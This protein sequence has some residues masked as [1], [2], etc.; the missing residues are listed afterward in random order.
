MPEN[1]GD[2]PPFPDGDSNAET[3]SFDAFT[4]AEPVIEGETPQ[5]PA[6][7][8]GYF[9]YPPNF[10]PTPPPA[11]S[12]R[13]RARSIAIFAGVVLLVCG[14]SAGA[15]AAFGTSSTPSQPGASAT[16]PATVPTTAR[17][18][19][20][21]T[22][23]ITVAAFTGT[24]LTG[25]NAAGTAVTVNITSTTRYGTKAHP[26]NVSQ[27]VAGTVVIVRGQRDGA[28]TI[29]ATIIVG[30]PAAKSSVSATAT[31]TSP[32]A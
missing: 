30:A 18:A 14:V 19:K 2:F 16:V 20:L 12:K 3:R 1:S 22:M 5:A 26:F 11:R 6:G 15:Y 8:P 25:T 17:R 9:A 21:Q 13:F 28:G 29:N 32:A 23:R 24:T 27:L 7:D 10:D 31:P 4:P